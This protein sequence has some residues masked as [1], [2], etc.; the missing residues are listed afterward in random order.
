M[1]VVP[2]AQRG[3]VFSRFVGHTRRTVT[4]PLI[5]NPRRAGAARASAPM[6]GWDDRP[7]V[8]SDRA[9]G[10]AGGA[11]AA[12]AD[13]SRVV[14]RRARPQ[15]EHPLP[16]SSA[17]SQKECVHFIG[18]EGRFDC[19]RRVSRARFPAF[20]PR[21]TSRARAL[22]WPT[23]RGFWRGCCPPHRPPAPTCLLSCTRFAN[24]L[25]GF[26]PPGRLSA[27]ATNAY[28]SE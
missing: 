17:V 23:R 4:C 13:Q 3:P 22:Q 26:P 2:T 10:A 1:I 19:T 24:R 25:E 27:G 12:P 9:A 8:R 20:L 16:V 7:A 28:Y 18:P 6:G 5:I 11:H 21:R 14:L 15:T